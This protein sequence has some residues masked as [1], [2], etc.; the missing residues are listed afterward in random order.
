M[1][2][3]NWR[4]ICQADHP[5]HARWPFVGAGRACPWRGHVPRATIRGSGSADRGW[6][7]M[8]KRLLT[9]LIGLPQQ[10]AP[11]STGGPSLLLLIPWLVALLAAVIRVLMVSVG[12]AHKKEAPR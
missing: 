7:G 4:R 2:Q 11:Q 3:T 5:S 10:E 6:S 8:H 9:V 12:G 1:R